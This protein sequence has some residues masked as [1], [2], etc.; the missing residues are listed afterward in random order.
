MGKKISRKLLFGVTLIFLFG[1]ILGTATT[2][3][4]QET[5][6]SIHGKVTDEKGK[7][8]PGAIISFVNKNNGVTFQAKSDKKGNYSRLNLDPGIYNISCSKKGYV[9][10]MAQNLRIF[11]GGVDAQGQLRR[12]RYTLNFVLKKAEKVNAKQLFE[13]A[14]QAFRN[15]DVDNAIAKLNQYIQLVPNNPGAYVLLGRGYYLKKQWK[16]SNE[17]YGKFLSLKPKNITYQ[18]YF[19][20]GE[21]SLKLGDKDKAEEYFNKAAEMQANN[22]QLYYYIGATYYNNKIY[23]K[24]AEKFKKAMELKPDYANAVRE[25]ASSYFQLKDWDNAITYFE[26]YLT[27]NPDKKNS[28]VAF[29]ALG[30]AYSNKFAKSKDKEAA[31]KSIEYYQKYIDLNPNSPAVKQIQQK[32]DN[33]K[34]M[35][36]EK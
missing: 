15:R 10:Q 35:I 19:I 17:A 25:L 29:I 5:G 36:G 2:A 32:I 24:A 30:D 26:K 6:I 14:I 7:P 23:D 3:K 4:T 34:S 21:V 20:M 12:R 1:F 28:S 16:E 13:Q 22:P 18:D 27:L 33:L 11:G 31:K 9:T 8:I